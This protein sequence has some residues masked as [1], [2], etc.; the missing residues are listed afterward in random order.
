MEFSQAFC[1]NVRHQGQLAQFCTLMGPIEL[2][3]LSVWDSV[4]ICYVIRIIVYFQF[5][6][7][8]SIVAVSSFFPSKFL[9]MDPFIQVRVEVLHQHLGASRVVEEQFLAH[10]LEYNGYTLFYTGKGI[11][12]CTLFSLQPILLW[13][14]IATMIFHSSQKYTK[15]NYAIYLNQVK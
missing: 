12:V 1:V 15:Q 14:V 2:T 9:R 6:S 10:S 4:S 3:G 5:L 11:L 13:T 8:Y 7:A